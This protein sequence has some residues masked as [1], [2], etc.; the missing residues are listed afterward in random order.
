MQGRSMRA[1]VI[2][3][4]SHVYFANGRLTHPVNTPTNTPF[5]YQYQQT[6]NFRVY[7]L[8]FPVAKLAPQECAETKF[9]KDTGEVSLEFFCCFVA[10]IFCFNTDLGND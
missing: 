6:N 10:C 5:R 9:D 7:F 1:G 8:L 2:S 3:S 4:V